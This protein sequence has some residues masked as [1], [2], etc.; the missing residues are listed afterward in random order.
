[1]ET[2]NDEDPEDPKITLAQRLEGLRN[3]WAEEPK[4]PGTSRPGSRPGGLECHTEY[5]EEPSTPCSVR[6]PTESRHTLEQPQPPMEPRPWTGSTPTGRLER[7]GRQFPQPT[8][9][10]AQSFYISEGDTSVPGQVQDNRDP[11]CPW[12]HHEVR[13][14]LRSL[15]RKLDELVKQSKVNQRKSYVR[16][17]TDNS[18][19]EPDRRRSL[20]ECGSASSS[21]RSSMAEVPKIEPTVV[22][23]LYRQRSLLT[24]M[25]NG[26]ELVLSGGP[27]D[28]VP[29]TSPSRLAN[30]AVNWAK[31][32]TKSASQAD[33]AEKPTEEESAD[34]DSVQ[35]VGSANP[36]AS[37][38]IG[39][40]ISVPDDDDNSPE[41]LLK[42]WRTLNED[43]FAKANTLLA[44]R[45]GLSSWRRRVW[46]FIENPESSVAAR[47]F[48]K[49]N[50][51]FIICTTLVTV[52][53]AVEGSPVRGVPAAVIETIID[54]IF[55]LELT[56]RFLCCPSK[57]VWIFSVFTWI[58]VFAAAPLLVRAASGWVM[59]DGHEVQNVP[60]GILLCAVPILR[61]LKTLRRFESFHLLIKAFHLAAEALPVLLYIL[62]VIAMVFAVLIYLVEPRDNIESLPHSFWLSIVT[63]TTVGYGDVTPKSSAGSCIIGVLVVITVLYMAIPLGI[64]GNA[65]TD[66]WQDRDRILLMQRTRDR[67]CQWGY[68]AHDIPVLFRITDANA[69]G[70]LD[71]KEFRKLLNQMQVG[72]SEERILKLF[73]SFDDDGSGTVDDQEFVRALF[74][75]AY[76]EIY[77]D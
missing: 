2:M 38:G 39:Q 71:I 60:H 59:P 75:E 66:T 65:F 5:G 43:D 11:L 77:D 27:P 24:P 7:V 42:R 28:A 14:E 26:L 74:P 23:A 64:I 36:A 68:T 22:K 41:G 50:A 4:T 6:A 10:Q 13:E 49:A 3:E 54:V 15:H 19:P 29:S 12:Y 61:I 44:M 17:N 21:R 8:T 1:M 31:K 51:F 40:L 76:H 58:D 25:S 57:H 48:A 34:G 33:C 73:Q 20:R 67:L 70:E 35:P 37:I 53:Q 52:A 62:T 32:I 47:F 72:F 18:G 9:P 63:M 16:S 45:G 56:L 46:N 55:L 69:D 30:A